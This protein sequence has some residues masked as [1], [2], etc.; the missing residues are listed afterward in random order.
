MTTTFTYELIIV[1]TKQKQYKSIK[2]YFVIKRSEFIEV[3]RK[4]WL[5]EGGVR[6]FNKNRDIM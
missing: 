3:K 5:N 6:P 1:I 2:N 4:P